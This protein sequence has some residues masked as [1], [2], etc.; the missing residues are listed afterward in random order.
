M[1]LIT[2]NVLIKNKNN[3]RITRPV[4]NELVFHSSPNE[5]MNEGNGCQSYNDGNRTKHTDLSVSTATVL[6][7][8]LRKK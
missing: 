4:C 2:G 5:F 1:H 8:H 7:I 6:I 3:N